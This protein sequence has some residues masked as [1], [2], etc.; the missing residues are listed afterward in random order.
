MGRSAR[1]LNSTK[2]G[3]VSCALVLAR[4]ARFVAARGRLCRVATAEF[5]VAFRAGRTLEFFRFI[6]P[7]LFCG[8]SFPAPIPPLA[9]LGWQARVP[10][11]RHGRAKSIQHAGILALAR[12]AVQLLV[13]FPRLLLCELRDAA[14][15]EHLEV[16]QHCRSDGDQ[17]AEFPFRRSH[18]N[19]LPSRIALAFWN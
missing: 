9:L 19:P 2:S 18:K 10:R 14:D 6:F 17:V 11:L 15:A 3:V 13:Q 8:F 4:T 16:A 5:S 1:R 12:L 7:G